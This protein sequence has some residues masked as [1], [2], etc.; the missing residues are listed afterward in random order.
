M[1]AVALLAKKR[2][3]E[4]GHTEALASWGYSFPNNSRVCVCVLVFSLLLFLRTSKCGCPFWAVRVP[5]KKRKK[6]PPQTCWLT[7][8]PANPESPCRLRLLRL[9]APCSGFL[10]QTPRHFFPF[11]G[12][13]PPFADQLLE[14]PGCSW[15]AGPQQSEETL[16]V[17]GIRCGFSEDGELVMSLGTLKVNGGLFQAFEL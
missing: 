8:W 10:K 11:L 2:A 1:E 13:L 14:F 5:Q 16:E 12:G 17:E 4:G 9:L 15:R 6:R 7:V 3:E